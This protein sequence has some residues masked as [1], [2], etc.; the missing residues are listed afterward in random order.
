MRRESSNEIK[1]NIQNSTVLQHMKNN[2]S[3]TKQTPGFYSIHF[4]QLWYWDNITRI[5]LTIKTQSKSCIPKQCRRRV[6]KDTR[7]LN[8]SIKNGS[9]EGNTIR[10]LSNHQASKSGPR[11]NADSKQRLIISHEEKTSSFS[12]KKRMQKNR[13]IPTQLRQQN[14]R[15]PS[16]Q[17][18]KQVIKW[19]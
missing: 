5:F 12:Q 3:L 2:N 16:Q 19:K 15:I 9:K 11:G 14:T 1:C 7:S 4:P 6:I 13:K 10:L 18:Q 17:V 8:E